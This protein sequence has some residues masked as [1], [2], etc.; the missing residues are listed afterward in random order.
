MH[1][2]ALLKLFLDYLT[3]AEYMICRDLLCPIPHWKFRI[4]SSAC[5]FR[6]YSSSA[7]KIF[8][9]HDNRDIPRYLV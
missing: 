5:G 4:I 1:F 9:A 3:K 7:A 8:Y 2:P 6:L